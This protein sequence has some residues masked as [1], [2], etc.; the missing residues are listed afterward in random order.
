LTNRNVELLHPTLFDNDPGETALERATAI[1]N[2]L[3]RENG[4]SDVST[5]SDHATYWKGYILFGYFKKD[6]PSVRYGGGATLVVREKDLLCG[7]VYCS[8]DW[9]EQDIDV[10]L[11][12]IPKAFFAFDATLAE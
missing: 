9:L 6:E 1:A 3:L 7:M 4:M 11:A 5:S 2:R 10:L 8:F 12:N